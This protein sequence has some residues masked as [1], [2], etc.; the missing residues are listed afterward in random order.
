MLDDDFV[1]ADSKAE[2]LLLRCQ[3]KSQRTWAPA[4]KLNEQG[5]RWISADRE[6]ELGDADV[7]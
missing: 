5:S 1:T 4:V 2:S 3:E 6:M 7:P